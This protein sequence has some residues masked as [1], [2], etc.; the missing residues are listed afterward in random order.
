MVMPPTSA[1][2]RM[3]GLPAALQQDVHA[4]FDLFLETVV[5]VVEHLLTSSSSSSSTG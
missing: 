5:E 3:V 4:L 2:V 1:S